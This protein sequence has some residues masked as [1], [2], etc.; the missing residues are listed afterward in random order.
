MKKKLS[1]FIAGLMVISALTGCDKEETKSVDADKKLNIV[2]TIFPEYDFA[3]QIA[4]DN[5]NIT[6]LIKPGAES[7]SFEPTPQDIKNIQNADL[8]IYTGGENDVWVDD[9]LSSMGENKPET[10]KLM[11][12]VDTIEEEIVEGME[13]EHDHNDGEF[14]DSQVKDRELSD[15][16]GD[17]QSV[18][19]YLQDGSLDEVFHHKAEENQDKTEKEYK[20]YYTKG[21][22]TDVERIKIDDG[23]ITFYKDGKP[24]TSEY[25]YKGFEILTY[26][27]GKKGVR[28]QF[29][30]VDKNSGAPKYIQFSD[31]LIEPTEDLDHFHLYF[32]DEG[33]DKLLEELENWPTYYP[34]GMTGKEIAEEMI[35]HNHSHELD[36]H[37]WTSPKNVIKIAEILE[38]VIAEKDPENV[39]EY[40]D[41]KVKFIKEL[42]TLD[43]ELQNVVN[44][45]KRKTI[46]FGDRFPFAY[47]AKDYGLNYFA[48]F[49]GCSTETEASPATVAFLA[50]KVKEEQ[51]PIVFTIEFSNGKIAD[52]ICDTTNSKK[53]TLHSCHNVSADDFKNGV[54]Y[55]SLMQKNIES[56]REALN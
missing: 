9:I 18:Y 47:L 6:M 38:E 4:G 11:D 39:V 26:E 35:E 49:S 17:W 25:T 12:C 15:W 3:R 56:L 22:K 51:I 19:P 7:H 20:E 55:V 23:K 43:E 31:H 46:V 13:H 21:Y 16:E 29:E 32:G 1:L 30:S 24:S 34:N 45:A 40:A 44:S 28:Y 48:A 37:V 41:N 54:T 50:D 27:S 36:E 2:T 10:L 33:F 14:E 42:Y 8:F 53:L 52:S 5:A